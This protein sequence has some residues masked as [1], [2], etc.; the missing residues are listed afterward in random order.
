MSPRPR[1][2]RL[3]AGVLRRSA[4]VGGLLLAVA[5]ALSACG[6]GAPS[7]GVASL[8]T[9]T[10]T[11]ACSSGGTSGG[12]TP[13]PPKAQ[14][15]VKLASRMRSHGIANF[16]QPQITANGISLRITP[17][18]GIDPRSPPSRRPSRPATGTFPMVASFRPSRR[19]TRPTT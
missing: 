19:P 6:A 2:L 5:V 8:G 15:I 3:S 16:P 12:T 4:A 17:A 18:S 11:S 10:T 13:T 7:A 14:L 1:L 9:T